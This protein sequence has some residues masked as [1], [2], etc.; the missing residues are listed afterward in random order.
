MKKAIF[1]I[2]VALLLV[3]SA[4]MAASVFDD[5]PV[6]ATV[7]GSCAVTTVGSIDFG[8]LDP[9]LAPAVVGVVVQPE[10]TCSFG[11]PWSITDDDGL[12][13][14]GVDQNRLASTT[15]GPTEYIPYT[16]SYTATGTGNGAAQNFGLSADIAGGAYS[17]NSGDAYTD[18][19][20]FTI[21][22]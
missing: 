18:T 10:I 14:T 8:N 20:R 6:T 16:I 15:L 5:V 12:N 21:T 3:G 4:A 2:A 22:Y 9:V 11:T 7:L 1:M 13:E 17:G 19:I